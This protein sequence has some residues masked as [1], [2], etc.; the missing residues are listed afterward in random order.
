MRSR[1]GPGAPGSHIKRPHWSAKTKQR[2]LPKEVNM[3]I[4]KKV[5]GLLLGL[6]V[7]GILPGVLA[8]FVTEYINICVPMFAGGLVLAAIGVYLYLR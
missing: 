2:G 1:N 6:T 3:I 5:E 7:S 8:A 4:P